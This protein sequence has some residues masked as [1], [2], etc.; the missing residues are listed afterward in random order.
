MHLAADLMRLLQVCI[1]VI[2]TGMTSSPAEISSPAIYTLFVLKLIGSKLLPYTGI[3]YALP[4]VAH[5]EI[6]VAYELMAR[7]Y[8]SFR[9]DYQVFNPSSATSHSFSQTGPSLQ[10]Q[11]KMKEFYFLALPVIIQQDFS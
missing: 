7:I 3:F 10:V 6:R 1:S 5:I 2:S 11:I 9:S 8:F 4:D